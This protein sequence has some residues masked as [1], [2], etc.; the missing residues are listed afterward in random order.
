MSIAYRYK[1]STNQ[2]SL[3]FMVQLI[4]DVLNEGSLF[5]HWGEN[6]TGQV[7]AF[8]APN[9]PVPAFKYNAGRTE[10]IRKFQGDKGRFYHG[11]AQFFKLAKDFQGE[12]TLVTPSIQVFLRS[13]SNGEVVQLV[14]GSMDLIS[15]SGYTAVVVLS[16]S[17][18]S[19]SAGMNVMQ[20]QL[21]RIGINEGAGLAL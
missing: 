8:F 21:L 7:I 17:N 9:K 11:I 5:T 2:N 18:T 6:I 3:V 13:E 12:V 4:F 1:I 14:P 16:A 19:L 10:L 20:E 15:L